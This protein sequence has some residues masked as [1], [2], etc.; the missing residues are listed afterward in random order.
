MMFPYRL[1]LSLSL[2]LSCYLEL[3]A[4]C[5]SFRDTRRGE[6]RSGTL[7]L[8]DVSLVAKTGN[9]VNRD[10]YPIHIQRSDKVFVHGC[11]KFVPALAYLFCLALPGSCLARF[12]LYMAPE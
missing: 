2:S 11:E 9:R 3:L 6:D 10:I 4:R 5:R 7:Y 12:D 8:R 1:S